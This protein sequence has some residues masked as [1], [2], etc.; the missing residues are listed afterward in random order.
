MPRILGSTREYGAEREA[1]SLIE[2]LNAARTRPRAG[3]SYSRILQVRTLLLQLNQIADLWRP[4]YRNPE[5]M[6]RDTKYAKLMSEAYGISDQINAMLGG[7]RLT[8]DVEPR[9]GEGGVYVRWKSAE[10]GRGVIVR[11][12]DY[13][14]LEREMDEPDAAQKM[15]ALSRSR[16]LGSVKTCSACERWFYARFSHTKFCS[17]ECQQR[18]FR[19]SAEFKEHKRQYMRDLRKLHSQRDYRYRKGPTNVPNKTR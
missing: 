14:G 4:A 18:H 7:Y 5:L 12:S 10:T 13:P 17:R 11:V 15:L 2:W 19:T 16:Y 9:L 6:E 1:H 8:P 3:G